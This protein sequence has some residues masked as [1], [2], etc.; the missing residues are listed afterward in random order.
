MDMVKQSLAALVGSFA[1]AGCL[2]NP[3][4]GGL[5]PTE[6]ADDTGGD[7]AGDSTTSWYPAFRLGSDIPASIE[8][9]PEW[10][11]PTM[12]AAAPPVSDANRASRRS[13]PSVF[14]P[15]QADAPFAGG[16]PVVGHC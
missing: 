7:D 8:V 9:L 12:L 5:P 14:L 6:R 2:A 11:I 1:L 13:T 3:N 4:L 10:D 16:L 15:G